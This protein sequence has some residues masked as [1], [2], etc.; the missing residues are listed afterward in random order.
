MTSQE[1]F[2]LV[3]GSQD[4]T[5]LEAFDNSS[6]WKLKGSFKPGLYKFK[7]IFQ[8]SKDIKERFF[9]DLPAGNDNK[10]LIT[11]GPWNYSPHKSTMVTPLLRFELDGEHIH[12]LWMEVPSTRELQK[13]RV[14]GFGAFLIEE[15]KEHSFSLLTYKE[16]PVS[17]LS[18]EIIDDDRLPQGSLDK[19]ILPESKADL[20]V[21]EKDRKMLLTR[22]GTTHKEIWQKIEKLLENISEAE[23][24]PSRNKDGIERL[25]SFDW[26]LL[27][28]FTAWLKNDCEHF[29]K[30]LPEVEK[31]MAEPR[32][33]SMRCSESGTYKNSY[34]CD[35][36]RP[37]AENIFIL[38]IFLR[39][40]TDFIDAELKKRIEKKILYH[41][42]ILYQV[43]IFNLTEL[44]GAFAEGH[45]IGTMFG[46]RIA[47]I[48]LAHKY[49]QARKY[50]KWGRILY[51]KTL[52]HTT[53]D[54]SWSNG[55]MWDRNLTYMIWYGSLW[56]DWTGEDLLSGNPFIENT[57]HYRKMISMQNI[58]D[59]IDSASH[60]RG[61][62]NWQLDFLSS[63][64]NDPHLQF[65]ADSTRDEDITNYMKP[66][67]SRFLWEFLFNDKSIESKVTD[68]IPQTVKFPDSG[69]VIYRD[70]W[71]ND[72]AHIFTH[73]SPVLQY[74]TIH[75]EPLEWIPRVNFRPII[76]EGEIVFYHGKTAVLETF[77]PG[78]YLKTENFNTITIAGDGQLD[79][80][81]TFPER[82]YNYITENIVEH[83]SG[84]DSLYVK[85]QLAPYYRA[86]FKIIS[87]IREIK[88]SNNILTVIDTMKGEEK[89]PWQINWVTPLSISK[90]GNN[91]LGKSEKEDKKQFTF[92]FKSDS[93]FSL[94]NT[95]LDF[96]SS[97]VPTAENQLPN[98]LT[99]DIDEPC[100]E[101]SIVTKIIG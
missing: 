59:C 11:T 97:Y 41:S 68:E 10:K 14:Q 28:S 70:A 4:I 53:T 25:A 9:T 95:Q 67:S 3:I 65:M 17:L 90:Y 31:I 7:A 61:G 39:W 57:S 18:I 82:K 6:G 34:G 51:E 13:C 36:D 50:T 99:I 27:H 91:F 83:R 75:K 64:H 33:L 42:E 43:S 79:Q 58:T 92:E 62:G 60:R 24:V 96:V 48:T 30:A 32:W 66:Y 94:T 5:N 101:F 44:A 73:A 93:D 52:S 45:H 76:S 78:Y 72:E 26:I 2:E 47:G 19:I 55:A 54:G 89:L 98:R 74:D 56:K 29:E 81:R 20:F 37:Q 100:R 49:D 86:E 87:I 38:C 40:C 88:Y 35:N 63:M 23:K 71:Y 46:F 77:S 16:D 69:Y 80:G 15:D 1:S 8:Y 22:A 84:K 85:L 12:D 21:S